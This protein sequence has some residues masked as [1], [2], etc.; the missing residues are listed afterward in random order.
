MLARQE[1]Y[2]AMKTYYNLLNNLLIVWYL[3]YC[4]HF[5]TIDKAAVT[6]LGPKSLSVSLIFPLARSLQVKNV[7]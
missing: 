4:Q 3:C 2:S 5:S 1:Q 7:G 6:A